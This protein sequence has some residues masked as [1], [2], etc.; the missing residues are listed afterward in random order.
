MR[1]V[2]I[3]ML[4]ALL[5]FMIPLPAI[6]G[7]LMISCGVQR[8]TVLIDSREAGITDENGLSYIADV[9]EGKHRMT[10]MKDG[11]EP[12]S[13]DVVITDEKLT[14]VIRITLSLGDQIPPEI[15]LLTP[16]IRGMK[17]IIRD[18]LTEISG[19]VRD[20]SPVSS[21][22]VN[23]R[24]AELVRPAEEELRLFP[25]ANVVKFTLQMALVDG[26]NTM[27]IEALDAQNNRAM[28]EQT[29]EKKARSIA[30][31]F[32]MSF[33]ALLIGI[34]EY[35]Y[36]PDL[37]NP[38][39]DVKTIA[40]ELERNYGFT[41]DIL[42]NADKN[43]II[44]KIRE[45]AEK[46]YTENSELLI[47]LSGHGHFDEFAKT[48]YFV[49]ANGKRAEDDKI[50]DSYIAYPIIQNII[51]NSGCKHVLLVLDA[52]YGGTFNIQI[53][54]R[55]G[56]DTYRSVTAEKFVTLK[57]PFKTRL[58]LSSGGKEYVPD[59]RPGQHSPF[60]RKFL[61]GLR[62]YGGQGGI[63]TTEELKANYMNYVEPQP[64][65]L[66]FDHGHEAGGEFFFIVQ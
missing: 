65:L 8:A 26:D 55:G 57:L 64:Y 42:L 59:G 62:D 23:G 7:S 6:S 53:A 19:L 56:E 50:F 35:D 49:P 29:I 60:M 31:D 28:L 58:M 27:R 47:V 44:G 38:V 22:T 66:P 3:F 40:Q 17:L 30:E 25:G 36:W 4:I 15:K 54:M 48:G 51:T 39:N 20:D 18:N 45:V 43:R 11:Y 52:C 24:V 14:E 5:S 41:T 32:N 21:V 46:Q 12:Y 16:A 9:S 63:L 10:V 2:V 61:E 13:Q 1:R 33:N 34:D 37:V